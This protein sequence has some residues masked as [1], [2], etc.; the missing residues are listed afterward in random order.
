MEYN[1]RRTGKSPPEYSIAFDWNEKMVTLADG[2]EVPIPRQPVDPAALPVQVMLTPPAPNR[3]LVVNL[4]NDR[5]VKTQTVSLIGDAE[6]E[7][8]I[9]L[10]KAQHLRRRKKGAKEGDF[11]DIWI[12]PDNYN[13]PVRIE[14]HKRNRIFAFTLKSLETK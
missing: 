1:E 8:S 13:L 6:L 14:R 4:I 2:S 11:I 10:V 12:S 5:G 3:D 9:G 7:T